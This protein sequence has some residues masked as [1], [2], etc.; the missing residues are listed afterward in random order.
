MSYNT[1][2]NYPRSNSRP[3]AQRPARPAGFLSSISF[4]VKATAILAVVL[5]LLQ[6]VQLV[7]ANNSSRDPE[8]SGGYSGPAYSGDP[9]TSDE[10]GDP[11]DYEEPEEE[12]LVVIPMLISSTHVMDESFTP[13]N[14]V[15]LNNEVKGTATLK[16]NATV[17]EAYKVM[18]ADIK[19]SGVTVPSIISGYRPYSKQKQLYDKK[20]AEY[21]PNQKVTAAPGTSEHQYGASVDI[22]T[23]GTCQNDFG[24]LDIGKWVAQNS[25]KYGFVVR[26]PEDKKELTGINFEPWHLRYVGVAHATAMYEKDMCLEEYVD[27]LR[28]N[29]TNTVEETTPDQFPAPRWAGDLGD[30]ANNGGSQTNNGGVAATGKYASLI[31]R[32]LSYERGLMQGD[33]VVVTFTGDCTLGTWPDSNS[34]TNYT[35]RY[36]EGNSKTYSFDH[37]KSLFLNDDYTYINLET[38]LTTSTDKASSQY[39]NFKGSPEWAKDMIAA[40]GVDGCNTA[41]N[42]AFDW[43]Q[44]GYDETVSNIKAAGMDVGDEQSVIVTR[45]GNVELV[46][47]SGNYI[48]PCGGRQQFFGDDLTNHMINLVKQHKRADN[49]VI[50]NAHWGLERKEDANGDQAGPARK[51]IDAGADMV[52]GHHPHTLQGIELYKGKYIFYSLGNF[53]FGGKGSTDEV[54]RIA[55][56]LRARFAL[57]DGKAVVT[58]VTGVPCYTTS[59]DDIAV[60]NYQPKPLM[61]SEAAG[62][63][64]HL[65]KISA[66]MEYGITELDCPAANW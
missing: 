52:V 60:N 10:N 15:E 27:Y 57:R 50:V 3:R 65:L 21:G 46:L 47:I 51:F 62:I 20:V 38:T 19:E 44:K 54:N 8:G 1:P 48:Y 29:F 32:Y 55:L 66:R 40:S 23:D 45:L 42:H 5:V 16:L 12:P 59:A 34:A 58:G 43:G 53:A 7:I 26:Y 17:L 63:Q 31:D 61:G 6:V 18:Y 49:I 13:I 14:I 22:S 64:N 56:M 9:Y 28:A 39:Y 2:R 33:E 30:P 35:A 36:N 4:R 41:N 25:Y 37:V 11:V 24:K